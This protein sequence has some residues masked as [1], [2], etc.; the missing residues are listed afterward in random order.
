[1]KWCLLY[2]TFKNLLKLLLCYIK[3]KVCITNSFINLGNNFYSLH[4]SKNCIFI[5]F[6]FLWNSVIFS[7]LQT[8]KLK[9]KQIWPKW[10]KIEGVNIATLTFDKKLKNVKMYMVYWKYIWAMPRKK[11]HILYKA[12][13]KKSI[14]L[15][16]SVY[17]A[18]ITI[19]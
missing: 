2:Q 4:S 10:Y 19:N 15:Q 3:L 18:K 1:M 13:Y 14:I 8:S 5:F 6:Y 12:K 16:K 11:L 9:K 17:Q 7:A